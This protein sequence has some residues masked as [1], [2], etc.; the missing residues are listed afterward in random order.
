MREVA[1]SGGQLAP[2]ETDAGKQFL[3]LR[4]ASEISFFNYKPHQLEQLKTRINSSP[5]EKRA[6]V[7]ISSCR[8]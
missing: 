6:F 2:L 8:S 4:G 3:K 1:S 5:A 7:T